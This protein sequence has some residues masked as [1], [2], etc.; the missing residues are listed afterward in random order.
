MVFKVEHLQI[1]GIFWEMTGKSS[2][3]LVG[4]IYNCSFTAAPL[5][6]DKIHE[7][8]PTEL[9]PVVLWPCKVETILGKYQHYKITITKQRWKESVSI[10]L[11]NLFQSDPTKFYFMLWNVLPSSL[12]HTSRAQ[13]SV[14]SHKRSLKCLFTL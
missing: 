6:T 11:E 14:S 9:I 4:T 7:A 1:C 10:I 8:I 3:F 13:S 5:R 12:Q 2:E